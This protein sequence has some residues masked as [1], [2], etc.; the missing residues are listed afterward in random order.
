[1]ID[2]DNVYGDGVNV[3]SRLQAEARPDS[4]CFSRVVHDVIKNKV[5]VK[6]VYLGPRTLKNIPERVMIWQAMPGGEPHRSSTA[7]FGPLTEPET[8]A[9][10]TKGAFFLVL[11]V[12]LIAFVVVAAVWIAPRIAPPP[13]PQPVLPVK[14]K[15]TPAKPQDQPQVPAQPASDLTSQLDSL[16]RQYEFSKMAALLQDAPQGSV[17]DPGSQIQKYQTLADMREWLAQ[18]LARATQDAPIKTNIDLGGG[19]VPCSIYTGAGGLTVDPG[20]NPQLRM[21]STLPPDSVYNLLQAAAQL[22]NAPSMATQWL[23]LFAEEYRLTNVGP[24]SGGQAAL[25]GPAGAT[26]QGVTG[27]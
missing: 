22:P 3:A 16:R 27:P 11:S 21:L 7:D 17:P 6:A 23:E 24:S 9:I 10:G 25:G 19:E 26:N 15:K 18:V 14:K 13:A 20:S 8:G 5:P 4:I 12:A 2:G 1:V